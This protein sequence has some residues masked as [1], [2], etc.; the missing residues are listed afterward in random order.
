MYVDRDANGLW[1]KIAEGDTAG[2][3]LN[4]DGS[5]DLVGIVS[6]LLLAAADVVTV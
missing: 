2:D 6:A 3:F 5:V 1:S 4:P